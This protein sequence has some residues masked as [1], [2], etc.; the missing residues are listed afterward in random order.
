VDN[1]N[2]LPTIG[3]DPAASVIAG[4]V[5]SF[6]PYVNDPDGD[7]LFFSISNLPPWASFDKLTGNI[8]GTPETIHSGIYEDIMISVSDGSNSTV[9]MTFAI[10]VDGLGDT[11]STAVLSWEI[12]TTRTDGTVLPVNEINGY[13][14]YMGTSDND[15]AMIVDL[16][17]GYQTSYTVTDLP[18][19]TYHFAVTTYDTDDNESNYSN[20]AVK[21]I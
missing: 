19:G 13:R 15:L 21:E 14:V 17:D 11:N 3:G 2:R 12:P 7:E 9:A 20:I 5:Y 1:L 18:A 16:N 4:D 6:T 10:Q 8:S